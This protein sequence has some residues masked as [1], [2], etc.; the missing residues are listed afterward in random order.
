MILDGNEHLQQSFF[1]QLTWVINIISIFGTFDTQT[2]LYQ[3]MISPV[4]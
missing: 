2:S 4:I 3:K 1:P